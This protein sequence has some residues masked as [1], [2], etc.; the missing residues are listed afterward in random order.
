MAATGC[1]PLMSSEMWACLPGMGARHSPPS[2]PTTRAGA[3][4]CLLAR[5]V[6]AARMPAIAVRWQHM[7]ERLVEA[8]ADR[9][10]HLRMSRSHR[11]VSSSERWNSSYLKRARR[12]RR[13]A[14]LSSTPD[15]NFSCFDGPTATAAID[16][17]DGRCRPAIHG[18]SSDDYY[19]VMSRR[20][21]CSVLITRWLIEA[22]CR[23]VDSLEMPA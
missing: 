12:R 3:A 22:K 13:P 11:S 10:P 6:R 5:R 23:R 14:E 8:G 19:R 9:L 4:D 1:T 15:G 20:W 2:V 16:V 7:P 21:R 17:G 18:N